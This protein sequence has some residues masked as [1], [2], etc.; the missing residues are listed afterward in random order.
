MLERVTA[1]LL[2]ETFLS[3]EFL[4]NLSK[5]SKIT[6]ETYNEAG[7]F[8]CWDTSSEKISIGQVSEGNYLGMK[9]EGLRD[10]KGYQSL[11]GILLVD[12]HTHP[13]SKGPVVPSDG[14][15][16]LVMDRDEENVY[17]SK[18]DNWLDL[19]TNPICAIGK[20]REKGDVELLLY[21]ANGNLHDG[22]VESV[23]RKILEYLDERGVDAYEEDISKSNIKTSEIVKLMEE[24]GNYN[25]EILKFSPEIHIPERRSEFRESNLNKFK[26]NLKKFEYDIRYSDS[27]TSFIDSI[28]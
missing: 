19:K 18:N 10:T 7:F 6:S 4:E 22:N 14:D 15:L 25:V 26:K 20:A 16:Y 23:D 28:C 1:D 24:S 11:M 8:S 21:N 17:D 3:E 27:D 2:T 9:T 12:L 5:A 13:I